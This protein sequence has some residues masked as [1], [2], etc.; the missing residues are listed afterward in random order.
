M[1]LQ[2]IHTLSLFGIVLLCSRWWRDSGETLESISLALGRGCRDLRLWGA[3]LGLGF[4][5]SVPREPLSAR[6]ALYSPPGAGSLGIGVQ[7]TPGCCLLT[8]S[9]SPQLELGQDTPKAALALSGLS[10]LLG[11][12]R[13]SF[14]FSDD[15]RQLEGAGCLPAGGTIP[16]SFTLKGIKIERGLQAAAA[17]PAALMSS[18]GNYLC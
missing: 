17:H 10:H 3:G 7:G 4:G 9:L 6:G 8:L 11:K 5:E 16:V 1:A 12:D 15:K 13:K 2:S 18:L 14:F